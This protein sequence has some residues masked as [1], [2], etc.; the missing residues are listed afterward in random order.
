MNKFIKMLRNAIAGIHKKKMYDGSSRTIKRAPDIEI[1][2][3]VELTEEGMDNLV[4]AA[5]EIQIVGVSTQEV[6]R[7]LEITLGRLG[8][9]KILVG[10]ESNNW[11]K[12]HGYPMRRRTRN[13][14]TKKKQ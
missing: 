8:E 4:K 2:G 9:C 10:I 1:K 13:A 3:T 11:R 6:M 14:R 5:K 12:L 7:A